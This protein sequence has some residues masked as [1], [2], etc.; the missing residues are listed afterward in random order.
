MLRKIISANNLK[1]IIILFA[2]LILTVAISLF[3]Y[4]NVENQTKK[5]FESVCS[6][7]ENKIYARLHAHALI[8][9]AGSAYF[10]VSDTVTRDKWK[11]F[12]E[13]SK[14]EKN[15][16]GIQG[17]GFSIIIPENQLE[18][19]I[20]HI[21]KEGFPNYIINPAGDRAAYTSIIYLEPFSG[22]NLQAFG[23]DMFSDSTRSQAMKLSRDNDLAILS[24]KVTL[25]QE[26]TVDLQIGTLMY[27]PVYK[28]NIPIN[29]VEQRRSAIRGWVYSPYRMNNLMHGILGRWDETLQEKIHLQIYDDSISF[30]SLL[31]DSQSKDSINQNKYLLQTIA[32]NLEFNGKKWILLFTL[33]GEK[34]SYLQGNILIVLI[35][36]ITISF[37]LY[38]LSLLFFKIAYRSEHIRLQNEELQKLNATKDK[39]F[40]I[41]AHDLRSPLNSIAG[42]SELLMEQVKE[43]DFDGI[44]K[45]AGIIQQSSDRANELLMNLMEWAQSQTGRMQFNPEYFDLVDLINKVALLFTDIARQKSIEVSKTLRLDTQVYGDQAMINTILRNLI[46]NAVKFQTS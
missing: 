45:Y 3:T 26:T 44:E 15:L 33:T 28:Q 10:T 41:I 21:R 8:L 18:N 7:I 27:V 29:T 38:L 23:Y 1:A 22:R 4:R 32:L 6:E 19:H 42:F 46:S 24:G 40:S 39:F 35:S 14:I 36:G 2:G 20:Q 43:K 34:I 9:R 31:Y 16:P 12:Y 25:V 13:Y 11:A 30:Y 37:L 5:E 17:I